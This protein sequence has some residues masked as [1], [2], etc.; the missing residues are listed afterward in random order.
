MMELCFFIFLYQV[1]STEFILSVN[2][3]ILFRKQI[4]VVTVSFYSSLLNL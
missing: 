3:V 2:E 4:Y 1:L